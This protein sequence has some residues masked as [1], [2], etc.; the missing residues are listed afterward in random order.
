MVSEDNSG[1]FAY[2]WDECVDHAGPSRS[3]FHFVQLNNYPTYTKHV[4][5]WVFSWKILS[6]LNWLANDLRREGANKP[7]IINFHDFDNGFSLSDKAQFQKV[8]ETATA[9]SNIR[10]LAIFFAHIHDQVGVKQ[11]WCI[12]GRRVPLLYSGS[13]PGN[14]YILGHFSADSGNTKALYT[15]R[16]QGDAVT[17]VEPTTVP[18]EQDRCTVISN[19]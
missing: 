8:L 13:V 14:N 6:A 5:G 15:L 1:S 2:S 11:H 18:E 3:C 9:S 10:V 16:V 7:V 4:D 17:Y 12:G 19:L